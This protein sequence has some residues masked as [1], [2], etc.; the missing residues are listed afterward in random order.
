MT[1]TNDEGNKPVR[2]ANPKTKKVSPCGCQC[3][4]TTPNKQT[5]KK[6]KAR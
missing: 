3:G 5:A 4:C 2:K 1:N 6:P